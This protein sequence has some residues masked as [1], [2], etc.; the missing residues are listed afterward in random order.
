M[1]QGG[2]FDG[3]TAPALLLTGSMTEP[4][5]AELTRRAAAAIPDARIQVLD[6][7]GHFAFKTDA[8]IVAALIRDY[9]LY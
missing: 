9:V 4:A 1:Y 7:H 3:I 2:Q 5:L 8:A 6:G